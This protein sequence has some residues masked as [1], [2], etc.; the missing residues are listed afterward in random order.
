MI[1]STLFTSV[2]VWLYA[3]AGLLLRLLHPVLRSLDV[4]KQHFDIESR[5]VYSIGVLLAVLSTGAR[6]GDEFSPAV[7]TADVDRERHTAAVHHYR[8]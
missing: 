5:P 2:W 6:L 3:G 7:R 1:Y 8:L 4:L